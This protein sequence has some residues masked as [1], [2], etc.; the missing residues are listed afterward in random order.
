MQYTATGEDS[1]HFEIT[2][3]QGEVTGRL[4]YDAFLPSK[5]QITIGDKVVYDLV[6]GNFMNAEIDI[7]MNGMPFAE[8]KPDFNGGLDLVFNNGRSFYFTRQGLG[9]GNYVITDE[10]QQEVASM[11]S[12]FSWRTM[13][14]DHTI[15]VPANGLDG[16]INAILPYLLVYCAKNM[17]MRR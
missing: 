4:E 7:T 15:Y 1:R 2:N 9:T 12:E 17:R 6:P 10:D 3:E 11:Q 14:F 8:I 5:A 13:S 16:D